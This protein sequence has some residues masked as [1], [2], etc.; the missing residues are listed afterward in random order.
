MAS[1]PRVTPT[2]GSD[3]RAPAA[4]PAHRHGTSPSLSIKEASPSPRDRRKSLRRS[5]GKKHRRTLPPIYRSPTV[6]SE[7]ISLT[8]PE[9]E[10]L[11]ELLQSCFQYSL[12]NVGSSLSH[13]DGFNAESFNAS[14]LSA[15]EKLKRIL[16]RF[17]HNGTFKRCTENSSSLTSSEESEAAQALIREGISKYTAE[18]KRWE[19]L[20]EDSDKKADALSSLLDEMKEK[21]ASEASVPDLPT[22]QDYVLQS[23]PD[24]KAM[25]TQQGAVFSSMEIVVD[26]L[27]QSIQFIDSSLDENSSH[28]QQL[29]AKLKSRSFTPMDESPVRTF[30]RIFQK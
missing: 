30:L 21:D 11:S 10:R 22:S 26:E 6:L 17:S 28:L 27:Q 4:S 13:T 23:K 9:S 19:E 16:E 12:H 3:G 1:A 20:L 14:V 7:A 2:K 8:L 29:S 5:A 18:G 15:K 25:L 24:Y